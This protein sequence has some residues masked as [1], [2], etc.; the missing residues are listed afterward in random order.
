MLMT[1]GVQRP[2]LLEEVS[3]KCTGVIVP[4]FFE[5][6]LGGGDWIFVDEALQEVGQDQHFLLFSD[7]R[8]SPRQMKK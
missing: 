6:Q 2:L 1:A 8:Q 5:A 4:N 7:T 3:S